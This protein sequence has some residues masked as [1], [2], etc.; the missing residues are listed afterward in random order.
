MSDRAAAFRR[1]NRLSCLTVVDRSMSLLKKV[2][3][4]RTALHAFFRLHAVKDAFSCSNFSGVGVL[5]GPLCLAPFLR[6]QWLWLAPRLCWAQL[7]LVF[8]CTLL[9]QW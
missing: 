1:M 8:P 7:A 5:L 3:P 6:T 4:A 9:S 2:R